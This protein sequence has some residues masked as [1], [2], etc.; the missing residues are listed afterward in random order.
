M[1]C[2]TCERVVGRTRRRCPACKTKLP[3]WY[4]TGVI[5]VIVALFVAFKIVEAILCTP[6]APLPNAVAN[7]FIEGLAG[8]FQCQRDLPAM[9]R[10]VRDQV[11]EKRGRV[12]LEAFNLS[13]GFETVREQC[14]DRGA[15]ISQRLAQQLLVVRLFVLDLGKTCGI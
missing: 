3:G 4:V 6:H 15:R 1:T 5:G 2:P 8:L 9:M 7:L 10:L 13:A 11:T 12:R 14:A